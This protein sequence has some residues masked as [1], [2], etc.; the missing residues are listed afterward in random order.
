VGIQWERVPAF[1]GDRYKLKEEFERMTVRL[2]KTVGATVRAVAA[3]LQKDRKHIKLKS[4][5]RPMYPSTNTVIIKAVELMLWP[6]KRKGKRR[7]KKA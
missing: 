5:E 4:V 1:P 6:E 2:P 3:Q 7:G